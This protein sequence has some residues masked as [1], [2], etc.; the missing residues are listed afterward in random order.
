MRFVVI[1]NGEPTQDHIEKILGKFGT[2]IIMPV[3]KIDRSKIKPTDILVLSGG[4]QVEVNHHPRYFAD[5]IEL[6]KT[7][8][9]IIIGICL[10]MQLIAR[11]YGAPIIKRNRRIC[12]RK[13]N[14]KPTSQFQKPSF[15]DA[16]QT[17]WQNHRYAIRTAPR[18]FDIL[19]RSNSDIEII[20]H[21]TRPLWGVQF[22][23]EMSGAIGEK[24]ISG[25]I[26]Y[27]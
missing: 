7:H 21:R 26:D 9:G 17:V 10:G 8:S 22:H 11:A 24:I 27:E 18:E 13:I 4:N 23:P 15:L 25:I 5:E 12:R 14:I 3:N 1:D 16:S 20:K 2:C 19:A 6:I